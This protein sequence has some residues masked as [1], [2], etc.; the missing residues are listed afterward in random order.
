MTVIARTS[1][2]ECAEHGLP[3]KPGHYLRCPTCNGPMVFVEYD[4]V[5]TG[6][7]PGAV[8]RIDAFEAAVRQ[9]HEQLCRG[10]GDQARETLVAMWGPTRPV[11]GQSVEQIM[12]A[13]PCPCT[14]FACPRCDALPSPRTLAPNANEETR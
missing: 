5:P 13:E 14:R 1:R 8:G 2:Q 9:A 4:L 7:H 10:E 3:D 11:G 6:Q 12:A